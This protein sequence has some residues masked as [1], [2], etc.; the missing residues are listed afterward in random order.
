MAWEEDNIDGG[1]DLEEI[2]GKKSP[3]KMI[4]MAV[5][6]LVVLG[7]I[8]YVVWMFFL[9]PK[10]EPVDEEGDPEAEVVEEAPAPAVGFKVDLDRFILNLADTVEP[11]YLQTTMSLEVDTV[12]LQTELKN[13][14]D[15]KLYMVKTRDT[16]IEV[17]STKTADEFQD[18]DTIREI[19][20][21]I[22]FRLNN[23]YQEGKVLE[24][25]VTDRVIQ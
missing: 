17:L 7:G 23:I 19:R 24:V 11:R 21:E 1:V 5:V 15:P 9:K 12:E 14:E 20:K 2:G 6:G 10:P 25:Y 4:I 13:E 3:M 16:I 18:P 8:G 22:T